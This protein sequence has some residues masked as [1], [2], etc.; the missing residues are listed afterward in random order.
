MSRLTQNRWFRRFGF[1]AIAALSLCALTATSP[2]QAHEYGHL[3]TVVHHVPFL[4]RVF[5]GYHWHHGDYHWR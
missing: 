4:S 3:A 5:F 2:A 1:G